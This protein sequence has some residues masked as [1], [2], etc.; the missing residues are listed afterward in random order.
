MYLI[1]CH[2]YTLQLKDGTLLDLYP[3]SD[4]DDV[5]VPCHT[6]GAI[7]AFESSIDINMRTM[8]MLMPMLDS[9]YG[10]TG[11]GSCAQRETHGEILL[12]MVRYMTKEKKRRDLVSLQNQ[13]EGYISFNMPAFCPSH[14]SRAPPLPQVD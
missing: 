10:W 13:H 5:G 8:P 3:R 6:R 11:I 14:P 12:L 2:L 7:L 1:L 4:G 9:L